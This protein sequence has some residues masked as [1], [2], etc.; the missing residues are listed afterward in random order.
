[1]SDLELMQ[2]ALSQAR[3]ALEKGEVPVGAVIAREGKII[4]AAHNEREPKK[5]ALLHAETSAIGAACEAL[6]G[7]RLPGCTL[8]VTLEPCPMCA[9]AVLAAQLPRVVV[10]AS[11]EKAGAFGGLFDLRA[12][13]GLYRT[14]VSFG[15]C[16]EEA[17]RLLQDFFRTLRG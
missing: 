5:N 1:M 11:D 16:A 14:T 15:L 17:K 4:A 8:Y 9:G 6:G 12:C 10:G 7:W 13:K 3:L 2:A